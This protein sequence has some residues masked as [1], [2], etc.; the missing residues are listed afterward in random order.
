MDLRGRGRPKKEEAVKEVK[1]DNKLEKR[2]AAIEVFL[3][4]IGY[5]T[6]GVPISHGRHHD[7]VNTR[8]SSNPK[9]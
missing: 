7:G 6:T 4:T 5:S 8:P 3:R 2:V 1:V 9:F